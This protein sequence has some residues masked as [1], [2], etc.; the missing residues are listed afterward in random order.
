M[1]PS[2]SLLS[3]DASIDDKKINSIPVRKELY[4]GQTPQSF[5]Y[6]VIVDAYDNYKKGNVKNATEDCRLVLEN[7]KDVYLVN[8]EKLNFKITTM[9]DLL[10]LKS[11]IKMSK[12]EM[13]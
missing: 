2:I 11:V 7:N 13:K 5:K 4:I 10:L 6:S 12:L 3:I 8:G 9:E 1:N